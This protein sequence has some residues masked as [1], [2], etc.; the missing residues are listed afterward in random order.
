MHTKEMN[1]RANYAGNVFLVK[2]TP[3]TR[4]RWGMSMHF[5]N[6][7]NAEHTQMQPHPPNAYICFKWE[8]CLP[9]QQHRLSSCPILTPC[10]HYCQIFPQ[11]VH[12][13]SYLQKGKS[14]HLHNHCT[15]SNYNFN[16]FVQIIKQATSPE[17]T[18]RKPLKA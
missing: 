1:F 4:K 6:M 2:H 12:Q 10:H 3:N 11:L 15:S 14:L 5:S 8:Y 13:S 18:K 17:K 7:T 16:P 9:C